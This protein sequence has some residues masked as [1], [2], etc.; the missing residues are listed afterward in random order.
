MAAARRAR[1]EVGE[2]VRPH[3]LKGGVVVRLVTNQLERVAPGAELDADGRVLVV[4]SSRPLKERFVVQFAG[5]GSVE[6][7]EA[8]RGTVLYGA[9]LEREGVLW[10]DELVGAR[11]VATDGT[12]LGVV[13]AVEPNPASDLLVLDTGALVPARFVVGD[14]TDGTVVIDAPEGLFE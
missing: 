7:A 1:L 11:A 4:E 13:L 8:L 14:V 5:V 9:P 10:V 3:G 6:A 12:D 2:I